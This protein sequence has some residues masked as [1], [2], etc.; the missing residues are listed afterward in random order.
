M[1]Q[2]DGGGGQCALVSRLVLEAGLALDARLFTPPL[3][4]D[5]SETRRCVCVSAEDLASEERLLTVCELDVA[6][7]KLGW[8]VALASS[9]STWDLHAPAKGVLVV[10]APGEVEAAVPCIAALRAQA[11]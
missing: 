3:R 6:G 10:V 7:A 2:R 11:S 4:L 1:A 8:H 5:V 9:P